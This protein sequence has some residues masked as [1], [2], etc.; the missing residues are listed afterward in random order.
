MPSLTLIRYI[1]SVDMVEKELFPNVCV[2]QYNP[3]QLRDHSQTL[4]RWASCKK[5]RKEKKRKRKEKKRKEKKRK[6]KKRKEKK[7]KKRK[8]KKRKEKKKEKKK[9]KRKIPKIFQGLP[10]DLKKFQALFLPRK[11]RV[12]PRGKACKLKFY[13]KNY[14]NFFQSS[15]KAQKC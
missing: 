14:G 13:N 9:R 12:N 10:S 7:E 15:Y 5:K 11:L 6:E 8:E 2:I 4:V 3:Q 1:M